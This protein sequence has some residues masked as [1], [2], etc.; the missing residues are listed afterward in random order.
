MRRF[1]LAALAA[2]TLAACEQDVPTLVKWV[3]NSLEGNRIGEAE[4]HAATLKRRDPNG[5]RTHGALAEIAAK[6][7]DYA[8]AEREF[9]AAIEAS[10]KEGGTL[11]FHF[12]LGLTLMEAGRYVDAE[13]E[14]AGVAQ[15]DAANVAARYWRGRAAANATRY[16][17][18]VAAF[19]EA[20]KLDPNHMDARV[21][22]VEA[23]IATG[24]LG[25]ATKELDWLRDRAPT[26]A[27]VRV[28]DG[29]VDRKRGNPKDAEEAL[30]KA[31][32]LQKRTAPPHVALADFLLSTGKLADAEAAL[33]GTPKKY[34]G[35]A[36]VLLR[37]GRLARLKGDRARALE[38]L[39]RAQ[40]ACPQAPVGPAWPDPARIDL[41]PAD[42]KEA[43]ELELK[44]A[45]GEAAPASAAASA[46]VPAPAA[47]R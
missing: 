1:L 3:D 40:A 9:R 24:D 15:F 18:A 38:L 13:V 35:A 27:Y 31:F 39:G 2:L 8:T 42:L 34:A 12:R 36:G 7:R 4:R 32:A 33:A 21:G 25:T 5:A 43:I 22:R 14:F 37:Q 47:T 6:K 44:A 23:L 30:R 10:R 16:A 29:T 45:R 19:S 46:P 20:L 17:D 26:D 11:R 41:F 28:L